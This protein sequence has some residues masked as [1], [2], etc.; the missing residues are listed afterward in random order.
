MPILRVNGQLDISQ[1]WPGGESDGDTAKVLVTNQSFEVDLKETGKFV[2]THVFENAT[3]KGRTTTQVIKK[4]K[5]TIRFQG[6]DAP[7]LHYKAAPLPRT[8]SATQRTKYNAANNNFRQ[9]FGQSSAFALGQLLAKSGKGIINCQVVTNV[10]TPNE[11]FDTYGRFIGDILVTIGGKQ[12]DLNLWMV[13]NGW[14][15]PTFYNSMTEEEIKS[16]LQASKK[17]RPLVLG[18]FLTYRCLSLSFY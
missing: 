13:E 1:F 10:D 8:A 18:K 5:L 6:I 7:E 3:A 11:V 4:G 17:G 12:V 2:K 9:N 15:F 14:A 16:F